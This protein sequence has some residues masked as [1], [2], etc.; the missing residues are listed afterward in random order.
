MLNIYV[1]LNYENVVPSEVTEANQTAI[2][3]H[4][5]FLSLSGMIKTG[6]LNKMTPKIINFN[7]E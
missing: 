7:L 2:I 1:I 4:L 6:Y 3:I 5:A